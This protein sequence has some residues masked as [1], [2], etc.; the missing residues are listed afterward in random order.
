MM[1]RVSVALALM[2]RVLNKRWKSSVNAL[3]RLANLVRI[4]I[5]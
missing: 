3:V 4:I 2:K 5:R 1:W